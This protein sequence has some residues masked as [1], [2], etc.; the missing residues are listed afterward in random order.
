[1]SKLLKMFENIEKKEQNLIR[2][3]EQ[4]QNS[5]INHSILGMFENIEKKQKES[6]LQRISQINDKKTSQKKT[7]LK[8]HKKSIKKQNSNR[9]T[10]QKQNSESISITTLM[11]IYQL[12]TGKPIRMKKKT[13]KTAIKRITQ[14]W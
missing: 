9:T 11:T 12:L 10:E 1:M 7:S 13:I 2:T 5:E 4:S 3:T 8:T 6:D 14:T